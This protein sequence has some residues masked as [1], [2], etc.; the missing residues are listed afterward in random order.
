LRSTINPRPEPV[1][2]FFIKIPVKPLFGVKNKKWGQVFHGMAYIHK[3]LYISLVRL[4]LTLYGSQIKP[5]VLKKGV[6]VFH[7]SFLRK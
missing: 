3:R 4:E 6:E 2:L 7:G 1:K 5:P